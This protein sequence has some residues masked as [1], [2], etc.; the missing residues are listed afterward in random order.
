[1]ASSSSPALDKEL[2]CPICM[3]AFTDPVT[4]PCGHN[5]C[6]TCL[7]KCWPN[8][9]TCS[10]PLCN[11]KFS[12]RPK[13]SINTTLRDVAQHFKEKPNLGGSEV[14][15]DFCD[16]RKQKAVK[17][18]L[19]CQSSYCETHLKPHL[20][21]PCLKKHKLINPVGNLEDYICQKHKR[22]LGRF[23]RDDQTCVCLSCTERE[24]R[25]HNTVPVEEESREKKNQLVQTQT[26]IHQMIQ[27]REKKIQE[28]QNS[29]ELRKRNTEEEKS[30]R[31]EIFTD[32]IRSIERC[33]SDLLKMMEEQQKA[34]EKQAE[35]LIKEIN[36]EITDLKRRNTELE[37]LSHADDHL[38]LIQ[39]SKSLDTRPHTKNWTEIRI[40]SDVNVNSLYKALT[41]L[42]KTLDETLHEKLSQTGLEFV[43]N[44]AV[45]VTL[46][47]DTANPRLILSDDG[48]QV[49]HGDIW[50]YVPEN[51]KRFDKSVCVLAKQGFS[52][53]RFYYEVQ[54]KGKTEWDLG[55][56]RES[57]NRKEAIKLSPEDGFWTVV[58]RNENQYYVCENPPVSLSLRVRPEKIG[59]FVDCEEGLVSFYDVESRSHLY[60]FT[61]QTFTDK[62]YPYFSPCLKNKGENSNPLIIT[63]VR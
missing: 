44:F 50:Q 46:D 48:K 31:V 18:C 59:V 49:N 10:C 61:G 39:M 11:G 26:D 15:C 4:T 29:V 5:F 25:G 21:V 28:I 41:E 30:S 33:Q 52:S 35:D 12:K 8:S 16:E 36:Q 20:S 1:M 43:Q 40:D 55:V 27:D 38:H 57:I 62:L 7:S 51:P 23:C 45:D 42:K 14:F 32:L 60:S 9:R 34:A 56:A 2:Q 47:P 19:T 13:L 63:T 6:R 22:P 37:Q 3:Q 58:L 54:V 17:T 24:H 53:G